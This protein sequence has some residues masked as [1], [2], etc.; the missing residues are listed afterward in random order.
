MLC[1]YHWTP[2]ISVLPADYYYVLFVENGEEG[3]VAERCKMFMSPPVTPMELLE[4]RKGE[5]SARMEILIM[6]TQA[7]F[8]RALEK[9]DGGKFKVDRWT[10]EEG[11]KHI[12]ES[13]L[14]IVFA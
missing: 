10:R 6:E 14:E 3:S 8:C 7:E 12:C 2:I 4:K 1:Q 9:V 11:K 13:K 5:I